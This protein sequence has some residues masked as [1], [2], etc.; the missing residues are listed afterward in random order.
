MSVI[1]VDEAEPLRPVQVPS[2][3][4]A[5][6]HDLANRYSDLNGDLI[7]RLILSA[8]LVWLKAREK[9]TR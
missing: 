3:T 1:I 7:G 6:L 5:E 4:L 2:Y 9:E 8:F